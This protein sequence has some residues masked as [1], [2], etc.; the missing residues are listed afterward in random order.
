M[1]I[2][3]RP[4][5]RII[6]C[7]G[8]PWPDIIPASSISIFSREQSGNW[9][10]FTI[11]GSDSSYL[12]RLLRRSRTCF[13]R[14]KP[15][16]WKRRTCSE[17]YS[18]SSYNA[19]SVEI[20]RRFRSGLNFQASYTFSKVF[21]DYSGGYIIR[22]RAVLSHISTM[23]NRAWSG[24]ARILISRMRSRP[25][26]VTDCPSGG[27]ITGSPTNGVVSQLVSGWTT[28]SIFTWQ[29]GPPF[30]ILSGEGTL[31]RDSPV[32]THQ[33]GVH[34]I[35]AAA[36]CRPVRHLSIQRRSPADQSEV[37]RPGR[38]RRSQRRADLHSAGFAA[39]FVIH[40][41]DGGES[42]AQRV[43]RPCLF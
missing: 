22:R 41:R 43:Q 27:D 17:T 14:A 3:A 8:R 12:Y 32:D 35:D 37:Y 6:S 16:S 2:R 5:L 36:D 4:I 1:P 9:R 31:N 19:G 38:T 21:T 39:G 7:T 18:S 20:R 30:S 29:S 40:S 34:D 26:S 33:Y 25:T 15:I 42:A 11:R 10:T 24:R 23:P 28:S 13:A